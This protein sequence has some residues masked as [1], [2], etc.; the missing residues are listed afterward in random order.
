MLG[1]RTNEEKEC[2]MG[3]RSRR[4]TRREGRVLGE[5]VVMAGG[6]GWDDCGCSNAG[7]DAGRVENA[8]AL[9]EEN[10]SSPSAGV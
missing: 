6:S 2:R 4:L 9:G 3:E 7:S 5:E 10:E 1:G 8:E